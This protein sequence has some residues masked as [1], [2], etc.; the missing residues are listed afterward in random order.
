MVKSTKK[1]VN[2]E[3]VEKAPKAVKKPSANISAMS[4]KQHRE[5]ELQQR[6]A[7]G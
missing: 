7:K 1:P 3:K 5:Y 2:T 6:L 4:P